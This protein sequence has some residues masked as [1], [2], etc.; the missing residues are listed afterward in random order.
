LTFE[1]GRGELVGDV[2]T[3]YPGSG[4]FANLTFKSYEHAAIAG[5]EVESMHKAL[6]GMHRH[7]QHHRHRHQLHNHEVTVTGVYVGRPKPALGNTSL[8]FSLAWSARARDGG[9][10]LAAGSI[11]C[12]ALCTAN[13]GQPKRCQNTFSA[14]SLLRLSNELPS[15]QY[16]VAA[17]VL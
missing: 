16:V 7:H 1:N 8:S 17:C 13:P 5:V 11:P 12:P 10:R 14:V 3:V 4:L 2:V 6:G 9:L 15:P